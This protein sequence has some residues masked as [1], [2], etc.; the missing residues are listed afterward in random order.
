M[1][2]RTGSRPTTPLWFYVLR[3]AELNKGKLTGVGARDRGRDLPP[4]HG[5]LA[6]TPS[7]A[8]PTGAPRLGAGAPDRFTMMD[9]LLHA[10]GDVKGLNPLGGA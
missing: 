5:G 8:T 4:G 9:L 6:E 2:R 7:C 10:F 1:R 3:E